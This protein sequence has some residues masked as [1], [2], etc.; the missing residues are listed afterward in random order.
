MKSEM[1]PV[2]AGVVIVI[3][4]GVVGFFLWRGT[5][6]SGGKKPGDVGNPS[7]FAPGGAM[8]GK[9]SKPAAASGMPGG[10]PGR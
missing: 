8:V 7:P 5:A 6:G 9:G 10:P 2:I 3:L 1:N 4:L